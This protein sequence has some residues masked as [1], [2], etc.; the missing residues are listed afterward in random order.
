[1]FQLSRNTQLNTLKFQRNILNVATLRVK[2][3]Q[4]DGIRLLSI[5]DATWCSL[6]TREQK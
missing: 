5:S 4:L 2:K 1:M 6:Y 3:V